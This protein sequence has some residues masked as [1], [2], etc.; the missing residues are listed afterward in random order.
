MMRAQHKRQRPMSARFLTQN[1]GLDG[2]YALVSDRP[3]L[4]LSLPPASTRA[5]TH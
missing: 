1:V 4:S 5:S 2:L 3:C